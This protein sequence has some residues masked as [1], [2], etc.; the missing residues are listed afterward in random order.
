MPLFVSEDNN[1]SHESDEDEDGDA[2]PE[3]LHGQGLA[4][5][6]ASYE[7][8]SNDEAEGEKGNCSCFL[9]FIIVAC[10]HES[11]IKT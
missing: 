1:S 8:D 2:K 11:E 10:V 7:S 6:I 4:S 9:F 3:M 5:L